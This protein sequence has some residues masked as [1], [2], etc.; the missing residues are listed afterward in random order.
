MMK[1]HS[2]TNSQNDCSPTPERHRHNGGVIAT[3]LGLAADGKTFTNQ[4]RAVWECPL[5][6]YK[7][8]HVISEAEH[9]A[10]LRFRQAYHRAVLSRRAGFERLNNRPIDTRLT[11]SE[12]L[13]KDAYKKLSLYNR[14]TVIDICGHD[15][16]AR[17]MDAL[18][19]LRKGL[20]HLAVAWH[21]AAIEVTEHKKNDLRPKTAVCI[22]SIGGQ[23]S[24]PT[25]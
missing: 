3:A 11:P 16:L 5:D 6:A 9:L 13:L 18:E 19:K 24:V 23:F 8:L 7:D 21:S 25:D 4:Y 10:G 2:V 1:Q 15:Q 12:R 20:G 17:D 14:G 22:H